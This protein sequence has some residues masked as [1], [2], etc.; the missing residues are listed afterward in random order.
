MFRCKKCSRWVSTGLICACLFQSVKAPSA[1][2]I[3]W[4]T[5]PAPVV[6]ASSTAS[7]ASTMTS[8]I[9]LNALSGKT[10]DVAPTRKALHGKHDDS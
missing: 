6:V 8:P 4:I 7:V 2:V 1:G 5:S 10:Y 3:S 9:A